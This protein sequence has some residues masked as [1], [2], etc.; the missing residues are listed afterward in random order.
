MAGTW[1]DYGYCSES[2]LREGL[3]GRP[4]ILNGLDD[5]LKQ[6]LK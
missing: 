4:G 5:R 1:P 3:D 6:G 2:D